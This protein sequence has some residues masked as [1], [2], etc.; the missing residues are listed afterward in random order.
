MST[1]IVDTVMSVVA[2]VN[3][4]ETEHTTDNELEISM[5][6]IHVGNLGSNVTNNDLIQLFGLH[7]TP[8]LQKTC[9]VEVVTCEKTSKNFAIVKVPEA[10][11]AE[12]LKL[13]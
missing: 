13:N 4:P 11:H 1:E 5:K 3:T 12:L 10:V 9:S 7:A 2:E 6:R 8:V